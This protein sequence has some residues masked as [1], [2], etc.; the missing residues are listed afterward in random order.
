MKTTA[1]LGLTLLLLLVFAPACFAITV[2][3]NGQQ[4]PSSP[5]AVSMSGRTLLPMRLVFESLG[6]TVTWDAVTRTAVGVRGDVEVQMSIGNPIAYING[7]A[8]GLDVPPQLLRGTTYVP[9]RFPAEAFGAEVKWTAATQVAEVTLAPLAPT[10]PV[11]PV[12]PT[13]PTTP[14]APTTPTAPTTPAAPDSGTVTGIVASALA[15]RIALN[16]DGELSLFGITPT[17]IVLRQGIQVQSPTDLRPGDAAEVHYSGN[18]ATLIRAT[19]EAVTGKVVAKV[20]NQ[21]M[22]D[23]R[24]E[25]LQVQPEVMVQDDA[26]TPLTYADVKVG[27]QVSVRMT[28]GTVQVWGITLAAAAPTTPATPTP[29]PVTATIEQFY[30]NAD[31]PLKAGDVLLVTL[32]GTPAGAATYDLGELRVNVPMSE[33]RQRPGRYSGQLT[34]AAGMDV[35]GVPLVGHLRVGDSVA[36]PAQAELPVTIDTVAPV[37]TPYG[38]TQGDRTTNPSP[39]LAL[40]LADEGGSGVDY[41]SVT[42]NISQGDALLPA[43][44]ERQ[45]TLITIL[46]EPLPTGDI[47]VSASARDLAG[48]LTQYN[49][50][51]TVGDAPDTPAAAE[52]AVTHNA[53]GVALAS[54]RTLQV[55]ATGPAGGTA[56][57]TLGEGGVL[58]PMTELSESPGTYIGAWLVP[59][60]T[61]PLDTT[62][63]VTL[64]LP[65][66]GSL[67]AVATE[68]IR[69]VPGGDLQPVFI[70]PV[71]GMTLGSK[72]IIEGTTQPL[73][74]V[75]ITVTWRGRM[76]SIIE[77]SGQLAEVRVTADESGH[78]A[79]EEISLR[80]ASILPVKNIY[81]K[82]TAVAENADGLVSEPTTL[83]IKK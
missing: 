38:L 51:F 5:P 18:I 32:E 37:L 73:A 20:P 1:R 69:L 2:I 79:T 25:I 52:L 70:N 31:T 8:T 42:V 21:L 54:G 64:E 28:P 7:R 41:D 59:D 24:S 43:T 9:L 58:E 15:D 67:T 34:I 22:L 55:T 50:T 71:E 56:T 17:T 62:V 13:T 30:H 74:E 75:T 44:I 14:A 46:P 40:R 33:S 39:L 82:F 60:L 61:E 45:G 76:F 57:F 72:I 11:T 4:L 49:W 27:Q 47:H 35:S 68:P 3:V 80:V 23:S 66:G 26:G 63:R 81:Y 77:D 53:L 48:N 12:A 65:E 29:T 6:A 16:L 78:F 19:Y 36:E 10:A 83:E